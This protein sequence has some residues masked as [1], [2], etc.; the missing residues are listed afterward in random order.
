M[1][2]RDHATND[3]LS[4]YR[5]K[6]SLDRTPEPAGAVAPGVGAGLFVVHKHAARRLHW[7]LRLEMDGVLRSWAVP[8]GPSADPADKRLAVMVEDHP[9]AYGDF[10]G[11]IPEGNYGAGSVIVWDRGQWV[12]HGDPHEGLAKGKLLFELRGYKLRG[13][14]TLVK[15]KKSETDWL[16]IKER[17][18]WAKRG[19]SEWPETSVLSGL[20]VEDLASGHDPEP[21]IR[22]ELEKLGA[23]VWKGSR[24]TIEP[25]LCETRDRAFDKPGW[26]FELKLDGYRILAAKSGGDVRLITRN[27]RDLADTFPEVTRAVAALPF[28]RLVLDG[29]V[30]VPDASGRPSF[31]LLQQRARLTRAL[32]VARASVSSPAVYFVF[33]LI[34]FGD[35]DCRPLPLLER[36]RVLDMVLPPVGPIR[37]LDWFERDGEALMAQVSRLGLEGIIAKRADSRYKPGRSPDWLKI[38]ADRTGDFVVVGFTA[39]KG[40]RSGF[41]ALLLADYV[42]GALTY[43]GRAGSGFTQKDLQEVTATLARHRRESPPCRGP[44]PQGDGPGKAEGPWGDLTPAEWKAATWVD[45]IAVCEVRFKEWTPDGLL[46]H[47][48]FLRFRD[49]KRPEECVREGGPSAALAPGIAASKPSDA[50]DREE[51]EEPAAAPRK[52]QLTNTDK[53]FWPDEGYTKGDLLE[54]YRTIAPWLL[55]YLEDRPLV[56][57]RYPDG[58]TG[59]SFYQKDAP[60]FV[61]DWIRTVRIWSED[62]ERYIHYFVCDDVESLLYVVNLGSIPLHIWAS[63]VGALDRP[64]WCVLD[65]DP[66][67]AP[68]TDVI[69]V[70]KCLHEVC[71]HVGLPNF[72]KTTGKTGLH[73]LIP[74]GGHCNY[75]QSRTLGELL[76]RVAVQELPKIATIFRTITKR[77][78]RVYVDFLQNRWGQT[79]V[80]PFSVR[81]LPG[82]TVSTPLEWREVTRSLDVTKYTIRT[83][84]ARM[85]RKRKDPMAGV[86]AETPDLAGALEKLGKLLSNRKR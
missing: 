81:P 7:D 26:I 68:F 67:E 9:L 55:P 20:T 27:Q 86:L 15:I 60:D 28:S 64:D 51:K 32:D 44:V 63:R 54:Y 37:R 3:P 83:V 57:T 82:A 48:V 19:P 74:L 6:R 58:I 21:P 11:T 5:A 10:E 70:A 2:A 29:E 65:L 42:D 36:R 62:T 56:L 38:R 31:S 14:W 22:R 73:I 52:V 66:K 72:I 39:P 24:A 75:D 18:A 13:M 46:R 47:P 50:P 69:A 78:G 53:V 49:D 76:A 16:L 85:K 80:A 12:P 8:K 84:R 23:P 61:P 25:M 17:D 77:D 41:G 43:A 1:P 71:D 30:I 4:D 35:L 59:K 33:D 40:S 45:P 79:I 34:A